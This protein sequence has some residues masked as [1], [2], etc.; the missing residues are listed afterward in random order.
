MREYSS[1][2]K[3]ARALD[4]HE[5]RVGVLNQTL[6]LVAASL[7]LGRRVDEVDSE[8]LVSVAYT[9]LWT[10]GVCKDGLCSKIRVCGAGQRAY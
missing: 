5:E 9:P 7:M 4:V 3:A 8:S 1:D 6:E 10:I 2:S